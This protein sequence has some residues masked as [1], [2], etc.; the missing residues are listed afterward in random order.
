MK[1]ETKKRPAKHVR[2]FLHYDYDDVE[3]VPCEVVQR[4]RGFV[5]VKVLAIPF[6]HATPTYGDVVR[7][8][9]DPEF[10]GNLAWASTRR[11]GARDEDLVEAGG[12]YALIAR[13]RRRPDVPAP[14]DPLWFPRDFGIFS[15][16]A[17]SWKDREWGR[18]YFAAPKKIQPRDV[19]DMLEARHPNFDWQ[20]VHPKPGSL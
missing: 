18:I 9:K 17:T 6:L 11:G 4:G 15:S 14:A 2:V 16:V 10:E 1:P 7:A 8:K 13:L 5:D 12:Y 3:T 19:L 20:L